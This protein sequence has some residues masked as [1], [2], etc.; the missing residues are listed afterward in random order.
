MNHITINADLGN[1]TISRHIYGHF[2]EHLGHCIY[3]GF[4][5]GEDSPIPNT[6]GI[7][8]DVVAA[9]KAIQI[10]NLRWPGG[11]FADEYHWMDGIGPR[12]KRPTMI[13]THWGGVTEN[14]HFGTHEF[15]D[16]CAQL[17]TEPYICG[18]VG[19]GTVREMQEWVEYIT[20]DG[21]S[22][23]ADL[24]RENGRDEPWKI[25]FW[26]VGNE[27]WG[28]GGNMRPEYYAD[29]YR[30][31]ATYLRN[32][33]D[34]R[35]YK[36]ACGSHDSN[37]EWTEVLMRNLKTRNGRFLADGLSMHYYTLG[38]PWD[39]KL[40]ATDF[41]EDQWFRIM[42]AAQK[43]DE[44]VTHHS[45]IMD[46]YDPEKQI[47]MIFDEWGTWYNVEAGSN[48]GFLYQQNTLRDAL[49]A[50]VHLDIFNR[51]CDR[52][53]MANIAQTINVLQALILTEPGSGRMVLTPTYH[54]FE[55]YK[56]HHDATLLPL[57]LQTE[58]YQFEGASIPAL[59]ASASRNGAGK[60]NLTLSNLN[61]NQAAE[62]MVDLR[63]VEAKQVNGRILTDS[64]LDSHNTFDHAN[65]IHPVAFDDVKL[66]HN[67]LTLS[68]PAK[69][70]VALEIGN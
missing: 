15:F 3:G 10:P 1:Q 18:N 46:H 8:N 45:Q 12:S 28:C 43:T 27:N 50:A 56:G 38:A 70:V 25:R 9:L 6:R 59:S 30:R 67:L 55:M 34:N 69:S 29:E 21:V 65:R 14:N 39:A 60:I 58:S 48:P 36:I 31:Y 57:H 13:N 61:P 22:P 23:M 5:V 35:L 49:V 16:L 24:R 17:G 33:G 19:S 37:Y 4:W 40:N 64:K 2:S 63:G 20:F 42:A 26:G 66:T 47:G 62:I 32:F 41:G 51:H 54:V 11:C 68:L 7:R 53:K 44:L 52:V